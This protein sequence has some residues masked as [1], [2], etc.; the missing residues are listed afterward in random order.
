MNAV[1]MLN[2]MIRSRVEFP[3]AFLDFP[4]SLNVRILP[5]DERVFLESIVDLGP[6]KIP[7]MRTLRNTRMVAVGGYR[8]IK[9][10]AAPFAMPM[11]A[12][13]RRPRPHRREAL[14][15]RPC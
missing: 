4:A 5:D 14:R 13:P 11:M 2:S 8:R 7:V 12:R 3:S 15:S 9:E 1:E 6:D 10:R